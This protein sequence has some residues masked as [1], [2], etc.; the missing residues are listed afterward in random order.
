M[1]PSP[2]YYASNFARLVDRSGDSGNGYSVGSTDDGVV[3]ALKIKLSWTSKARE[4]REFDF[5]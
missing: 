3:P 4:N 5:L 2:L 1:A